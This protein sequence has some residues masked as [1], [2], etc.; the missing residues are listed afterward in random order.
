MPFCFFKGLVIEDN[1]SA[2]H[3]DIC[4]KLCS[5]FAISDFVPGADRRSRVED[6]QCLVE[7]ICAK[8]HARGS[9]TLAAWSQQAKQTCA[10]KRNFNSQVCATSVYGHSTP[11][12]N[13]LSSA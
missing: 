5:A 9:K 7:A 4:K 11:D 12:R 3:G 6:A 8:D 2:D 13:A 10:S 1:Y